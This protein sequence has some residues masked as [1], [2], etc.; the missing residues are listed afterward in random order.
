MEASSRVIV[1]VLHLVLISQSKSEK[2]KAL[3]CA[4]SSLDVYL[5]LSQIS[6]E[7]VSS[8]ANIILCGINK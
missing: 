1:L 8:T 4:R 2:V 7:E 3:K 6:S 5:R